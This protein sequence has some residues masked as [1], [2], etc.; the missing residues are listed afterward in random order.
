MRHFLFEFITG[1][2]L[3][4]QALSETLINEGEIMM[5]TL[6]N[7]L[8]ELD[9][10]EISLS[11]DSRLGLYKNNVEQNVVDGGVEEK[12]PDFIKDSDVSWL[13]APE[14]N[15]C[16]EVY[17]ELFI[18]HGNVFIGSNPEAIKIAASKIATNTQL[19]KAGMKVVTTEWLNENV[20]ESKTG[21]VVKPDD[22]VGGEGSFII[23]DKNKLLELIG[24][25]GNENFIVQPYL[26]GKHMSMSLL[27]FNG[28]VQLLSCNKQ[29]VDIEENVIK[30]VAIGV[31]E[32]MSFKNEML[33]I[34][35]K[36]VATITGFSGY[37]G[38]DLIA[39]KNELYVL[40]INPRFTT[41]YAG[42]SE[43]LGCNVTAKI[44]DTFLNKKIEPIEL[45]SAKPVRINCVHGWT[46][47]RERTGVR[48]DF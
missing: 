6:L 22:G 38:V 16:L 24:K 37:I 35:K 21:W 7:E 44:L 47:C 27:V 26:D 33:N 1:G 23:N 46:V 39:L 45:D 34:A 25:E 20:I 31:N 32:C 28:E 4:E 19:A 2:G 29:Y 12:L 5:Q 41:A 48:S 14:T 10:S 40:E 42:I 36:I 13:I 15:G 43:S 3:S 17:A 30:L 9:E 18:K 11:R 8:S